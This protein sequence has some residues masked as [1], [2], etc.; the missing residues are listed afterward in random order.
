MTGEATV[1]GFI[2]VG[3]SLVIIGVLAYRSDNVREKALRLHYRRRTHK[4]AK[5]VAFL[6]LAVLVGIFFDDVSVFD[7]NFHYYVALGAYFGGGALLFAYANLE[8]LAALAVIERHPDAKSYEEVSGWEYLR[9]SEAVFADWRY[10]VNEYH[11]GAV[12]AFWLS[13]ALLLFGGF[14][15]LIDGSVPILVVS[16]TSMALGMAGVVAGAFVGWTRSVSHDI[17]EEAENHERIDGIVER[18]KRSVD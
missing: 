16:L 18:L 1:A 7:S 15:G 11:G 5:S 3:A 17:K 2:A 8:L 9:R 10:L 13:G 14:L 4:A 12:F 6:S